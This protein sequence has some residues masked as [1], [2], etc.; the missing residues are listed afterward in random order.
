MGR[1]SPTIVAEAPRNAGMGAALFGSAA[2]DAYSS[3]DEL[4][5][6]RKQRELQASENAAQERYRNSSLANDAARLG[7]MRDEANARKLNDEAE[8]RLKLAQAG[9]QQGEPPTGNAQA[10]S[11]VANAQAAKDESAITRITRTATELYPR[12]IV[13]FEHPETGKPYWLDANQKAR[14]AVIQQRLRDET[15]ADKKAADHTRAIELQNLRNKGSEAAARIRAANRG[16]AGGGAGGGAGGKVDGVTPTQM[17]AE[18]KSAQTAMASLAGKRAR[19]LRY[20]DPDSDDYSIDRQNEWQ[21]DSTTT[22]DKFRPENNP[23]MT[24]AISKYGMP[25]S[26]APFFNS[27]PDA[28]VNPLPRADVE[29]QMGSLAKVAATGTP[30]QKAY[31][32]KRLNELARMVNNQKM[33]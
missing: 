17:T 10:G 11:P 22:V 28:S 14:D 31:A 2:M 9:A 1:W 21:R 33:R 26:L 25:E 27:S 18:L 29:R 4:R 6:R 30:A 15:E 3:L 13:R 8:Y 19:N 32:Q 23:R 24:A 5:D 16:S 12:N 7:I 20:I